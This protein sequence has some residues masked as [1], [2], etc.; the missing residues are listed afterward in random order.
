MG[1]VVNL[2]P[3]D[4]FLKEVFRPTGCW[5]YISRALAI[6]VSR[7]GGMRACSHACLPFFFLFLIS[8]LR[9]YWMVWGDLAYVVDKKI[10]NFYK[11]G[12]VVR[13]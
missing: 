7:E 9:Q 10:F 3:L 5:V 12:R 6:D 13:F 2:G 4:R 8:G 11:D 1:N